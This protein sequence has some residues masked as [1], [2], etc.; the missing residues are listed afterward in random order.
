MKMLED[1]FE[2]S[3]QNLS[4]FLSQ[5][6]NDKLISPEVLHPSSVSWKTI[7]L[8]FLAQTIY[9]F[10]KRSHY[11]ENVRGFLRGLRSKFVKFFMSILKQQ[12]DSSPSFVSVFSFMKDYSSVLFSSNN[13]YFAQKEPIK[14]KIFENFFECSG[15]NLSNFLCQ[16]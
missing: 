4:N 2:R 10:F 9:T 8:Y 13:I 14:M 1:F 3:G 6:W 16:F 7:P 15:Q 5:F 11:S 12:D